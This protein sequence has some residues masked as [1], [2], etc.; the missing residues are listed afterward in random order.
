MEWLT[1]GLLEADADSLA[2]GEAL[3]EADGLGLPLVLGLADSDA[4]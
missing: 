2:L 4:E 3:G 1:D